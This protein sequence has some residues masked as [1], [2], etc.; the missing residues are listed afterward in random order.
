[1]TLTP[2][3]YTDTTSLLTLQ[4]DAKELPGSTEVAVVVIGS[5]VFGLLNS[6]FLSRGPDG[7]T[8]AV[9]ND[10]LHANQRVLWKKL[11][12]PAPPHEYILAQSAALAATPIVLLAS[13]VESPTKNPTGTGSLYGIS[14]SGISS[15]TISLPDGAID[16]LHTGTLRTFWLPDSLVGKD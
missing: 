11:L 12:S 13:E 4:V 15:L 14:G 2:V 9:S 3:P 5:Q 10:L 6:P 8:L 7:V 16:G 1:M